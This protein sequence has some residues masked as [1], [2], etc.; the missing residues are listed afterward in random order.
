MKP[1]E[2]KSMRE[3]LERLPKHLISDRNL[4]TVSKK[5]SG[6]QEYRFYNARKHLNHLRQFIKSKCEGDLGIEN[7]ELRKSQKGVHY[8][9]WYRKDLKMALSICWF[10]GSEKRNFRGFKVFWPWMSKNQKKKAFEIPCKPHDPET[11]LP[12]KVQI[13][14][15]IRELTAWIL[16]PEAF[17]EHKND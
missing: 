13:E 7:L 14:I 15:L 8:L 9:Y 3:R 2:N 11:D 4:W 6:S 16:D 17:A 10:A 5:D 12:A 1:F